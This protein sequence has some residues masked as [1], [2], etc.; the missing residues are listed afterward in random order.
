MLIHGDMAEYW[1]KACA[2]QFDSNADVG[3]RIMKP[4]NGSLGSLAATNKKITLQVWRNLCLR[5]CQSMW[6]KK[7]KKIDFLT[8]FFESSLW[9]RIYS[10]INVM[11]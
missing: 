10:I 9:S 5:K 1:Y 11:A 4:E 7:T 8:V 6:I 2:D 3:D